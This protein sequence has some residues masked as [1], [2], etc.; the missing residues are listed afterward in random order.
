MVQ[1]AD[2]RICCIYGDRDASKMCGRYSSDNGETW[3]PEFVIRSNYATTDDW[4]DMGYPRLLKRSDGR[5][6]AVYYWASPERPQQY[7]EAAI[8]KP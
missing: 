2:G 3:A 5:L 7:I 6:V 1:L 4:S 8:W